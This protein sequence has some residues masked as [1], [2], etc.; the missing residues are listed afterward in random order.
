MIYLLAAACFIGLLGAEIFNRFILEN[1]EQLLTKRPLY[2]ILK[3]ITWAT[4]NWGNRQ[5]PNTKG[6]KMKD[7]KEIKRELWETWHKAKEAGAPRQVTNAI[8]DVM[9]IMD[10]EQENSEKTEVC[11]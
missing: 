10:K 9:V 1:V 5:H 2:G 3:R 6:N 4:F 11:S 7:L 8:I